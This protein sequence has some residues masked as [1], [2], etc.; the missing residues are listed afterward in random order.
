MHETR[1]YGAAAAVAD[2]RSFLCL[3]VWRKTVHGQKKITL[4]PLRLSRH[5]SE[6]DFVLAA[7]VAEWNIFGPPRVPIL[8]PPSP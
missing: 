8:R 7:A 5:K 4:R 1:T 6:M 3:S 2:Y